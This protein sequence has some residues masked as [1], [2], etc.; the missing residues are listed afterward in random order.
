MFF[1]F[2]F[3]SRVSGI[4]Q[5]IFTLPVVF[6]TEELYFEPPKNR[7]ERVFILPNHFGMIIRGNYNLFRTNVNF[8][9]HDI[10]QGVKKV[11]YNRDD[12]LSRPLVPDVTPM[13]EVVILLFG[14]V[15]P[16]RLMDLRR[17]LRA[18]VMKILSLYNASII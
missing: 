6:L 4:L 12:N 5:L 18:G 9:S 3:S 13:Q 14:R 1:E 7:L 10:L 15:I 11:V 2:P 17:T 16:F 8:P